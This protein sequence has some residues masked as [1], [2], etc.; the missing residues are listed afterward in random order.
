MRAVLAGTVTDAV[1][2][3]QRHSNTM[4]YIERSST[5]SNDRFIRVVMNSVSRLPR[6]RSV[7]LQC[8]YL[9]ELVPSHRVPRPRL[10]RDPRYTYVAST[11]HAGTTQPR[12]MSQANQKA[13]EW[14]VNNFADRNKA[15]DIL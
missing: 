13:I 5:S 6:I 3:I 10:E 9:L 11:S 12:A 8:S 15:L 14:I 1:C 7:E 2:H 4:V